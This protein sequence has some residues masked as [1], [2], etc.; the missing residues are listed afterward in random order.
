VLPL[1]DFGSVHFGTDVTGVKGT[2][3]ATIGGSAGPIGSFGSAVQTITMVT[4]SGAAKAQ[5]SALSSDGTSFSITWV[6]AGP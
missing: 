2:D 5:P 3:S 4:G 6:R 1:A